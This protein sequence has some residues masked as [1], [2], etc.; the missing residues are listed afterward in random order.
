MTISHS[1]SDKSRL[2]RLL[3]G[4]YYTLERTDQWEVASISEQTRTLFEYSV[5]EVGQ[6]KRTF[7]ETIIY[8]EDIEMVYRFKRESTDENILYELEFRIRTKAGQIRYV[9]DKYTCYRDKGGKLMMEG[10]ISEIQ[11]LGSKDLLF[12]QL[13]AY[14]NAVDVNMIS[15]IT[16]KRGKIVYANQN[17]CKIS[18]YEMRELV[19]QNHR[20]INSGT[21]DPSFFAN[22]WTTISKGHLWQGEIRNRAKD[23]SFYWV[24]TVIIP[25]FDEKKQIVNYLSLRMPINERKQVEEQKKN[26]TEMLERLAFMVAHDVRGPLCS[27]LGLADLL[28]HYKNTSKE[29]KRGLEFLNKAAVDLDHVTHQL[30]RFVN[31]H[32]SWLKPGETK[33][34]E[35]VAP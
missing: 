29:I 27:I 28:L 9:R 19:G 18:K 13:Q 8:P 15:S 22:L 34:T 25:I 35:H 33:Q 11:H 12:H 10:Y 30:T 31:E 16:D 2:A 14:R 17:F 24:D 23:G 1:A 3:P 6:M 32:E 5:E 4:V 7:L 26:Y 20:I 21:H